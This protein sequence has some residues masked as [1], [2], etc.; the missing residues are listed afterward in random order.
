MKK[1]L[2]LIFAFIV[3]ATALPVV[4]FASNSGFVLAAISPDKQKVSCIRSHESDIL[5]ALNN[6]GFM[7]KQDETGFIYSLVGHNGPESTDPTSQQSFWSFWI[8]PSV[9]D[10]LEFSNL[11]PAGVVPEDGHAYVFSFG[12]GSA[13]ITP[14]EAKTICNNKPPIIQTPPPVTQSQTTSTQ[15]LLNNYS[16]MTKADQ[17]WAAMA[18]GSSNVNVSVSD[19]TSTAITSLARVALAKTAQGISAGKEIE[20][21]TASFDGSQIGDA[22]LVNDD[23]FAVLAIAGSN[24]PWLDARPQVFAFIVSTQRSDG[25][26][27]FSTIGSGDVDMTAAALWAL[28]FSNDF[29]L[30]KQTALTYLRQAQNT[31]GGFGFQSGQSSNVPSTAWAIL[32]FQAMGVGVGSA[33]NYLVSNRQNDGSWLF[34]GQKS[35]LATSYAV[36]ALSGK[37]LPIVRS[38]SVPP[39]SSNTPPTEINSSSSIKTSP[40]I[41]KTRVKTFA[42]S[43]GVSHGCSASASASASAS[44]GWALASASATSVCW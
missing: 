24:R 32:G 10:Q 9:N 1:S 18:L 5:T 16:S 22:S 38:A 44:D 23:I 40:R 34:A 28:R 11:G 42:N 25:S 35:S 36:L 26:F 20:R 39:T 13:P 17:D 41:G 43:I 2:L 29:A 3:V 15:Y 31:D 8:A 19:T 30:Q 14:M 7:P 33:E 6:N 4:L 27:G 21:I 12:N 37:Q